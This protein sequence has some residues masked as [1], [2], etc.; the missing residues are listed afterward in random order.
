MSR[1]KDADN[2]AVLHPNALRIALVEN[3]NIL[4]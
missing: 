2:I 4:N 3:S 1:F